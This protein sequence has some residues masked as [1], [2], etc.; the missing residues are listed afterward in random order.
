MK[1]VRPVVF[2]YN[3][4]HRMTQDVLLRL[5]LEGYGVSD[6]IAMD[7]VVLKIPAASIRT[8][9]RHGALVHPRLVAERIGAKYHVMQHD[10]AECAAFLRE[11]GP[12][13]GVI[14]G[15][16]ILREPVISA[17][18]KGIIN[19]HPGLIPEC[20]GLDAMLWSIHNDVSLGVTAHLIDKR[21][22]AGK[23][24]VRKEIHVEAD[25]TAFDLAERLYETQLEILDSAVEAALQGKGEEVGSG[26]SYNRKMPGDLE[27]KVLRKLP[28][29]IRRHGRVQAG[30]RSA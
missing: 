12:E 8:K 27:I 18:S 10:G 17:F 23:I 14:A 26:T 19:L 9:V 15:A 13:L 29:Y 21:V 28:D 7:P 3:F 4:P 30:A 1:S 5:F 2:A 25:D 16:R 6:V 20:R 24:L 22:D 11:A